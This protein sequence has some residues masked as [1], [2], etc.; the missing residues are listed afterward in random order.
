MGSPSGGRGGSEGGG[1]G[2]GEGGNSRAGVAGVSPPPPQPEPASASAPP[3]TR[4]S[5][6][7]LT[8]TVTFAILLRE[9][10]AFR[11]LTPPLSQS[12]G[13]GRSISQES[14]DGGVA[15]VPGSSESNNDLPF[16]RRQ[17]TSYIDRLGN[18]RHLPHQN[19]EVEADGVN[20]KTLQDVVVPPKMQPAHP[21]RLAAL[22]TGLA[23]QKKTAPVSGAGFS[24]D[25]GAASGGRDAGRGLRGLG[26]GGPPH[27]GRHR[28]N[29]F[30]R[31]VRDQERR[32]GAD[33]R[34]SSPVRTLI[35]VSVP[36]IS[37]PGRFCRASSPVR[38]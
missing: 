37:I 2:G 16:A 9:M 17:S 32:E 34:S 8:V 31:G 6:K 1:E 38:P 27:T 13:A 18:S 14:K 19:R 21:A 4:R 22:L 15:T 33:P 25:P 12:S 35:P 3:E 10:D 26:G 23:D 20:Q 24:G 5:R 28:G 36:Q 29:P 11:P 30:R 7:F